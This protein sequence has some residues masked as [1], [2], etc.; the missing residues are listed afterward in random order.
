MYQTLWQVTFVIFPA[1]TKATFPAAA[2]SFSK[3]DTRIQDLHEP[4]ECGSEFFSPPTRRSLR[5][6]PYNNV[7][8]LARPE[9]LATMSD[10][11][12]GV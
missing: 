4:I 5:E 11:R 2:M 9:N 6:H 1:V 7:V 12:S 3:R 8:F 10:L